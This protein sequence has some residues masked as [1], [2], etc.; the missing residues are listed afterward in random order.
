MANLLDDFLNDSIDRDISYGRVYLKA[1]A[2]A[3]TT[4]LTRFQIKLFAQTFNAIKK[5]KKC[6]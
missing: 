4:L 3:A 2:D 5:V 6:T 1:F